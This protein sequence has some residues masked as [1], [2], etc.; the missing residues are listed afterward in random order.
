MKNLKI[1]VKLYIVLAVTIIATIVIV[2]SAIVNMNQI[3]GYIERIDSYNVT[4]LSKLARMTHYFDSLRR[5]LRDAVITPDPEKTQY[6]INEVVRRYGNLVELSEAYLAHLVSG[7][8]TSGEEFDTITN[9]V[10]ALPGAAEIV[11]RIAG[12]AERNNQAT[13]LH[14]LETQC[15]PFTQSMNDWLEQLSIINDRQSTALTS[16]AHQASRSAYISMA[17]ASGISLA[18]LLALILVIRK[19]IVVPIRRMVEASEN[20]AA[21]NVNVNL[22]TSGADETGELARKLSGVAEVIKLMMNDIATLSHEANINGDIEYRVDSSKYSGSY[23]EIFAG[24]NSFMD[25]FVND[26]LSVIKVLGSINDGDFTAKIPLLPGKKVVLNNTVDELMLHL[27]QVNDEIGAMINAAA[28]K[29][30]LSYRIDE[31]KH[32]GG[33]REIM[34]GL[35]NFVTAV[36]APLAE[37]KTVMNRVASAKFDTTVSGEYAGDFLSMKDAVNEVIESLDGYIKEI[38]RAL[39]ALAGGDLTRKTT[40][41]FDGDFGTIEGSITRINNNLHKTITD[42][43]QASEKVLSGAQQIS[44][45]SAHLADGAQQQATSL[46]ELTASVELISRQST[47]NAENSHEANSISGKSSEN[48]TQGNNA[49][50]EMLEAMLQ[51]KESG[52]AISKVNKVIQDIAFQTNLLALNAAVEAARAGEHGK[53]FAVVAEEVRSLAVRSQT[54]AQETTEQIA[55]TISRVETG[56]GIAESTATALEIM[57][58]NANEVLAIINRIA[59]S[60][61]Q[62]SEA[63]SKVSLGLEQISGVVQNSSSETKQTATA[64]EE[65]N[66]QAEALR[67]A[68]EYFK[69]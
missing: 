24:F 11:L 22:D 44:L 13:A 18:V 55:N 38:D 39:T 27:R 62:Q 42:I 60:S 28:I 4:P 21:G 56:S 1:G 19:S 69:L 35:N 7:G 20:I 59:E 54:A 17:I 10:E 45:S 57:V 63:V 5:Q 52:N 8:I 48:A 36:D 46:Q 23:R 64:A 51:I 2:V 30:Q 53:G 47:E 61:G 6:H 9:F 26:M 68:V 31:G 43:N 37:I 29:G 40:M 67:Q 3:S 16:S 32:R 12:Y 15:V 66:M 50:K 25:V 33:W 58:E 14:Y 49:M 65:L 34:L 41:A